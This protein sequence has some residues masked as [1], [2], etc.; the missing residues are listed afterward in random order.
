MEGKSIGSSTRPYQWGNQ[1]SR[2]SRMST[3]CPCTAWSPAYT[4]DWKKP[5]AI[6]R[7]SNVFFQ[8][9]YGRTH[10]F[11]E[12]LQSNFLTTLKNASSG[13]RWQARLQ[14]WTYLYSGNV[15]L[16]AWTYFCFSMILLLAGIN[17]KTESMFVRKRLQW[18]DTLRQLWSPLVITPCSHLAM[19]LQRKRW[20]AVWS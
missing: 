14:T 12:L 20:G 3:G 2:S 11:L 17:T 8:R 1:S 5:R 4:T 13:T 16:P 10:H 7:S 6:D 19:P 18:N 15:V 9:K